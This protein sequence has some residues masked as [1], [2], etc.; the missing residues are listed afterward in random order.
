MDEAVDELLDGGI[1]KHC[2]LGLS[3]ALVEKKDASQQ[4]LLS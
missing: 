1:I 2:S 4:F 3:V